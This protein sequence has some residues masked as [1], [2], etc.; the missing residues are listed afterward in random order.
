MAVKFL[1]LY[2]QYLSIQSEI[3]AAIQSVISQSAFVGGKFLKNFEEDFCRFLKT[4]S[5]ALGVAN[6]TDALEIA[7][8]ALDLPRDSEVLI[9]ANT[10]AA[11][12]E[13]VVRN[14]LK[15]VFVDCADDYTLDIKDLKAKITPKSRA[16]IAVHLYGQPCRMAEI[17]ELAK[18]YSLRVI[19]DCAQAHGARYKS[20]CVGNFGDIATFSF[21]PG[22]NLGAYGDGGMILAKM[23]LLQKCIKI[24]HHGGLK[25]YEHQIVGRNSRLDSLQAAILS[26]KIQYLAQ[27]NVRRQEIARMYCQALQ[28][29]KI[30]LPACREECEC[31]WHLFVIRVPEE[32]RDSL[33]AYLKDKGIECGLHYPI[34]LPHSPAYQKK[35]YVKD[36]Q[37][38]NAEKWERQ[39]LSLP[40]G[41]HLSDG[42]IEEVVT[43]ILSFFEYEQ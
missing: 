29:P 31:V 38:P 42:D 16:I 9:P 27:W 17:L 3:D 39:I 33:F 4:D 1:D 34:C 35:P 43:K 14:G 2:Q 13:A 32:Q 18:Q 40:M 12:A 8:E 7:I 37:N 15:I 22:K 10:F 36:T 20:V 41:E 26:V 19:E 6:G 30:I 24:A 5:Y 23:P 25:K 11:T 28:H 21:Y